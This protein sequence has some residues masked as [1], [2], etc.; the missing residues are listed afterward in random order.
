[1]EFREAIQSYFENVLSAADISVAE[2]ILTPD[3]RCSLPH[4]E[5][6][7]GID[8]ILES[9]SY[10]SAAFPHRGIEMNHV[11]VDGNRAAAMYTLEMKHT[12]KYGNYEATGKIVKI[13]GVNVFQFD[14]DKICSIDVFFNPDLV[15][16]QIS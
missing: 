15:T 11:I 8:R 7:V 12:G 5:V 3:I 2:N 10:S 4:G 13:T 1:M 16:Q 9:V 14:G 6:S